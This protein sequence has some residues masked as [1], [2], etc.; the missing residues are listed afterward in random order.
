METK[1][2]DIVVIGAGSAGLTSAVG[3]SKV[4]KRVLLVEREHMGG[5]CTN[6][7]CIP[8]KALLHHAKTYHH[9]KEIA[10]ESIKGEA[11]RAGAFAYTR[12]IVDSI[13]KEET[14]EAFEKIGI[15]VV[16]GEA[17]FKSKCSIEF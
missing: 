10:G 6:S 12:G 13:L 7:G 17:A 9:A 1:H 8:S 14:P 3:F 16:M 11:Y 15:D 5:E 4:G 2:Y